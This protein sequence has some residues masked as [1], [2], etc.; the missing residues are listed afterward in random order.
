MH[1]VPFTAYMIC[2]TVVSC[3]SLVCATIVPNARYWHFMLVACM[4]LCAL[5][6][7]GAAPDWQERSL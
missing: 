5:F 2:F 4:A 7:I 6:L 1:V 3:V